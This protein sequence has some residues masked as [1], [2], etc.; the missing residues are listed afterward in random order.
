MPA[1]SRYLATSMSSDFLNE[2]DNRVIHSLFQTTMRGGSC[3]AV[4]EK[5]KNNRR[6]IRRPLLD[7]RLLH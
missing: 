6:K 1:P 5:Y 4:S 2:S 7:Q 3:D